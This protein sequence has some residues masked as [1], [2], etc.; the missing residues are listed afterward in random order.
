MYSDLKI[1]NE[2]EEL[3]LCACLNG[4]LVICKIVV[5]EDGKLSLLTVEHFLKSIKFQ[6]ILIISEDLLLA[7][8]DKIGICLISLLAKEITK[9]IIS[10]EILQGM[11]V[12]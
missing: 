5:K 6:R 12:I 11:H 9:V 3:F 2:E 8:I 1:V 10:S 4:G 7:W